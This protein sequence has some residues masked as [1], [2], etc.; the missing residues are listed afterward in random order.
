[1]A[2]PSN[3]A[4]FKA[5]I[6]RNLGKTVT[7]VNVSDEQVED[8]LDLALEFYA[9]YHFDGTQRQFYKIPIT[10]NI[11]STS[12]HHT[13][14][15]SG[16]TGYANTDTITFSSPVVG[17]NVA[18]AEL[19]TY[20]NGTIETV[21]LL[22]NGSDY[23]A[24]PTITINTSTGT[25]ASITCELGGYIDLPENLIGISRIFPLNFFTN[26]N[27][28]FSVEYQFALNNLYNIVNSQ[29]VPF[30]MAKQHIALF[31]QVLVGKPS[32]RFN[33]RANRLYMDVMEE[34]LKI[35]QY[36]VA[37]TFMVIDP[38]IYPQ[39]W[40]DR[41]LIR[42]ATALVKRIYGQ[43]LSKFTG[44][45]MP[46]GVGFN[47]TKILDDAQAEIDKLE[48]EMLNSWSM[49]VIDSIA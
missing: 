10:A 26:Y 38:E 41:F 24:V 20:A 9:D 22:T 15:V 48:L 46:G 21:N 18:T 33:R 44:G 5:F 32:F 11:L 23:S 30:Y 2:L 6:L 25:G 14:L 31:Q 8:Q 36:L 3:R 49:P 47:G 37:E 34:R 13:T 40:R 12:I 45:M 17:A 29:L 7:D 39:V 1:M 43:N 16:G 4:E 42:Y 27:D 28:M 19:T 35:G